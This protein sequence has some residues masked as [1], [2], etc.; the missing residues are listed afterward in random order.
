MKKLALTALI[1]F[2]LWIWSAP[3]SFA[4][5]VTENLPERDSAEQENP[6]RGS[7]RENNPLPPRPDLVPPTANPPSPQATV[8]YDN[9]EYGIWWNWYPSG[10]WNDEYEW[11]SCSSWLAPFPSTYAAA[12]YGDNYACNYDVGYTYGN[13]TTYYSYYLDPVYTTASISFWSYS[14]TECYGVCYYDRRMVEVS[15]DGYNWYY[16]GEVGDFGWSQYTFDISWLIGQFVQLRFTFDSGDDFI[17]DYYGWLIDE[18]SINGYNQYSG[19]N[20]VGYYDMS[21]GQGNTNQTTPI[22][23]A[24][25]NPIFLS[26]LT[27]DSL[28]GIDVLFVQNPDNGAYGS[29]YISRLVE[30]ENAVAAGMVLIIHDRYV[31]GAESILPGGGWFNIYRDFN[32]GS[33]IDVG[34]YTTPITSGPGGYLD[35]YSLDGGNYSSHGYAGYWALPYD[36]KNVLTRGYSGE[37]VT[38]AYGYGWGFVV[39]S[40]IPLDHYLDGGTPATFASTYAP[41]VVSYGCYLSLLPVTLSSFS[42]LPNGNTIDFHWTT[43][44]EAGV[45]GFNLYT[46]TESGLEKLNE[47][48]ILS[49]TVGSSQGQSYSYQLP[50]LK[51]DTFYLEEIDTHGETRFHGPYKLGETSGRA[52]E[53]EATDWDAIQSEQQTFAKQ[54]TEAIQPQIQ[55]E[56]DLAKQPAYRP[57][58]YPQPGG[59]VQLLADQDGL[60]RITYQDLLNIG[61][62]LGGLPARRLS[63]FL[64][65][66]S[67]PI[68]VTPFAPI[69]PNTVIEFYGQAADSLYTHDNVYTLK[70]TAANN[71]VEIDNS[72]VPALSPAP[73]YIETTTIENQNSY[74]FLAQNDDPWYDTMLLAYGSSFSQDFSITIDDYLPDATPATLHLELWGASELPEAPDHRLQVSLNGTLLADQQFDGVANF[75][76]NL[77]IPPGVLQEGQNIIT[78]ALPG[79]TAMFD[80]LVLDSYGISYP[81]QFVA[82]SNGLTFTAS[83]ELFQVTNL[84]LGAPATIYRHSLRDGSLTRISQA[85]V[86]NAGNGTYNLTFKGSSEKATYLVTTNA[87]KLT[88]TIQ[89]GQPYHDITSGTADYLIITHPSFATGLAPLIQHHQANG[90]TVKVANVQDIYAQFGY[91]QF[92]ATAIQTYVQHAIQNMGVQYIL[93]VGGDTYDYFDY[94]GLGSISFIPSL[95]TATDNYVTFAPVDPLFTDIDGDQLPD[96]AIGR[97][98]VRTMS[99]LETIVQKTLDYAGKQYN[100]TALLVADAS[101]SAG[102]A[103]SA[104]SNQLI[105]SL[106]EG[107]TAT[108]S[109]LEEIGLEAARA[110]TIN[111]INNGVALTNYFGHSGPSSWTF[112]G[113]FQAS[114]AAALTNANS[115]TVVA[116]WGCWNT[117][118]V[119]P[120]YNTLAHEFMLNP[121]GG[122]AAVLGSTTLTSTSSDAAL[123]MRLLPHLVQPGTTIGQ[124]LH[125]AKQ[126]LAATQPELTDVLLGWTLLGDPAALVQP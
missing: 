75:P 20:D 24:G 52:P 15:P 54:R 123:G 62:D 83:G 43:A 72:P 6:D 29:E 49:Q 11:D 28:R 97:F 37:V 67:V 68:F 61:V 35:D 69:G 3:I 58:L 109:Y 65:G 126:E 64:R 26:D 66:N 82:D 81:R 42:A 111:T 73:Y 33:N 105:N 122:A 98:P 118:H 14:E 117:Y 88:P 57:E 84:S 21:W 47:Q 125:L 45:A 44:T 121:N 107:W 31:D 85:Q 19:C 59:G 55:A 38:F 1:L 5:N 36:V 46:E 48:P 16:V 102:F 92:D 80:M 93:L 112:A 119:E 94:L 87:G 23:T 17:N 120:A 34:D 99:E 7:S 104:A 108:P 95:Y 86:E 12:Y 63:L 110:T 116:Q 100:Q 40:S 41:N 89:L 96:A 71:W 56:F 76:M 22:Y 18:V 90:L 77:T 103:F 39:Y 50:A 32:D 79:N 113:L 115:P 51:A 25:R 74:S 60:Y 53:P 8:F 114:D 30:I 101:D 124:A 78:L 106:P 9:F 10:L 70:A 27:T 2:V 4:N 91:G 13:L